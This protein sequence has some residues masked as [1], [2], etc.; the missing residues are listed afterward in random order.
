MKLEQIYT[1]CLAQGAYY[2]ESDGEAAIIDPLREVQSYID[3]A[4]DDGATIKYVFLTHFH[5]DFVSGHV[6]L[7][8]KTGAIIVL[9]PHAQA[10]YEFLSAR[11]NEEFSLGKLTIKLLHTPGHTMESS[12][13]L[14]FDE[15][16]QETSIFTG[17]TLFIGD[18]G[19]PDLAVKSDL[20]SQDLAGYLYD[21]LRN[22][23]LPLPDGLMVYPA[24]GAGSA[25]GK[26]M[27][28]ETYD[29]LG[30][31]KQVNYALDPKL[32]KADF[33]SEITTG[34]AMPPAYF[35]ENVAMNKGIN[36]TLEAI[37]KQGTTALSVEEF[38]EMS[39]EAEVLIL[40][41]RSAKSFVEGT[42]PGAWFIGL[43][44]TFAPWVGSLITDIKQ[45]IVFIADEGK[46]EE[47]VTRLARV[48]YDNAMGFLKGGMAAWK[49]SGVDVETTTSISAQEFIN[50]LNVNNN[51]NVL[52]VRK[53]G[54]YQTSHVE[55]TG[56]ITLG[57]IHQKSNE[58]K[59][60]KTYHIYCGGG[61]RSLIFASIARTKGIENVVN[62]EGGYAAIKKTDLKEVNLISDKR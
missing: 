55:N 45:K 60:D 51:L 9:G 62:I 56:F 59:P 57:E 23:I 54:E 38:K 44:G 36:K 48:G 7:A 14:L 19:R 10:G 4:A 49:A 31:Q 52:D 39:A 2:I 18:V 25:C 12:C 3:M 47:V 41:T 11:D 5:A 24:H 29:T 22:K 1:K 28:S 35:P 53:L 6:D 61:Y 8:Q 50:N 16:G 40:D 30:H 21:S 34:L 43:A 33:I 13:Y 58:L 42:V 17:D 26:N 32:S 20:S 15:Q 27:S 46:E 37:L